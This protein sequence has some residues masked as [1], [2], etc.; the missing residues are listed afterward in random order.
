MCHRTI[1]RRGRLL[2]GV[3]VCVGVGAELYCTIK[4]RGRSPFGVYQLLSAKRGNSR[5]LL[6]PILFIDA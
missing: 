6:N 3:I 5:L 2:L 4:R 1:P